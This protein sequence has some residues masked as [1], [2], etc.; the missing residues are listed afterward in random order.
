MDKSVQ[1]VASAVAKAMNIL[2][3]MGIAIIRQVF[4]SLEFK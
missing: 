2:I 3:L 1:S 4:V